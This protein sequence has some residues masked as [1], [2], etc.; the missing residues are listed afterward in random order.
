MHRPLKASLLDLGIDFAGN[1]K[2]KGCPRSVILVSIGGPADPVS[3]C[4]AQPIGL[5]CLA[6]EGSYGCFYRS[7]F[8]Q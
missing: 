8:R 6:E 5:R 1:R 7:C 3:W 2:R 4:I